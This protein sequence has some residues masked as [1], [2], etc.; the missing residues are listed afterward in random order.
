M[1][2]SGRWLLQQSRASGPCWRQ[3][4]RPRL[5]D[6]RVLHSDPRV[7]TFLL[8][9]E[10]ARSVGASF[11]F[12]SIEMPA[13]T[14]RVR[15][16]PMTMA[17]ATELFTAWLEGFGPRAIRIEDVAARSALTPAFTTT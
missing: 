15:M 6:R 8:G 2:R 16:T 13:W 10:V 3:Q 17:L 1:A 4:R 12:V 5:V 9:G 11:Q 14:M 7:V